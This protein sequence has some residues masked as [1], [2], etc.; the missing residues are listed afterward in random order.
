MVKMRKV[1]LII[2]LL[3]ILTA[4]VVL[5]AAPKMNVMIY[6]S[7]KDSQLSALKEGF[8]KKYPNIVFDFYTAGTGK[9][10]TK[11]STE[12]QAGGISADLIWV[13]EPTNYVEFKKQ[14]LLLPYASPEAKTIP[15]A[16]KD[17]D[18]C[19]CAARLV[20][21]G[22]VYNTINVKG[23]DIPKDWDDLLKPRFKGLLTMTDPIFSGTTLYTV[24]ALVQSEKYGWKYL[25][26]LKA[27]GIKL[28]QGSSDAPN[29]VGAGEYDVCIGVD[30]IAKDLIRQG[31]P[32]GFVYPASGMS[33][34]SS[35]IAIVKNTKNLEAAKILY[36]YILSLEGQQI[37]VKANTTPI[38]F[39]IKVE[40]V[41]LETIIKNA[42]PVNDE[43]LVAEKDEMLKRFDELMKK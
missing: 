35:P 12:Q 4:S 31:S 18:N 42:L 19:Y 38:R 27:N 2:C 37:L 34:V 28:V 23:N 32:V 1:L 24:A 15:A 7:M 13:G 25:E 6:S 20:G 17:P 39:E 11:I 29:K 14:G 43:R 10:M 9:V 30:Y 22:I 33:L 21:L 26:R 16:M 8:S 41:N 3:A 5:Q 40:D 36:D